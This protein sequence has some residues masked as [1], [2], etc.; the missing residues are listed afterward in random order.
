MLILYFHEMLTSQET[1]E[2]LIT[3]R[4]YSACNFWP[5]HRI[6]DFKHSYLVSHQN[7]EICDYSEC[8][9]YFLL[10][11]VYEHQK[12][13]I[14]TVWMWHFDG[15]SLVLE[16]L[17]YNISSNNASTLMP[18]RVKWLILYE[19]LRFH[20]KPKRCHIREEFCS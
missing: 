10:H 14:I 3:S 7:N 12:P 13:C 1:I 6:Y 18:L 19:V 17:F 2:S 9:K 4:S 5:F 15:A 8:S 20:F 16:M 11:V